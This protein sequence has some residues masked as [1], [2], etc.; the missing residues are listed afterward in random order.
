VTS[1]IATAITGT[2]SFQ[3]TITAN[4]TISNS[5][6]YKKGWYWMVSAAGTYVS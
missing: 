6:N 3:G 1:A 5:T 2:A 4:T